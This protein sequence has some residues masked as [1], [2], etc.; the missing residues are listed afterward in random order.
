[1]RVIGLLPP[2]AAGRLATT[3]KSLRALIQSQRESVPF[4][5]QRMLDVFGFR[6]LNAGGSGLQDAT[7]YCLGAS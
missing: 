2:R 7:A 1:M 6:A 4:V 5:C 3:C